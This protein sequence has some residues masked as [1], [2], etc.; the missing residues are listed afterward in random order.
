MVQLANDPAAMLAHLS[1][2]AAGRMVLADTGGLHA[3]LYLMTT[4][5]VTEAHRTAMGEAL[6]TAVERS[7]KTWTAS[8]EVQQETIARHEWRGR[9]VGFWHIHPPRRVGDGYAPGR[10]PGDE[11]LAVARE[12][13]Q[14]LT[15]VFQPDGFDLY[16]L[17]AVAAD[18]RAAGP[19]SPLVRHRSADWARRFRD[20]PREATP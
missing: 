12:K 13:G 17:S 11:D 7:F 18:P 1:A 6:R 16:D 20:R 19:P 14:F 5:P 2:S 3:V 10:P 4:R 15:L 9:Y 8:P